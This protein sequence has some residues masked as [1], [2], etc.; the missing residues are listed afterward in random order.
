MIKI[1]GEYQGEL[2]CVARHENSGDTLN[3]DAPKDNQGRGAAFSPTDLVAT[4]LATCIATTMAIAVRKTPEVDLRGLKFEVTKEMSTY[5]P[6][7]IA[8]LTTHLWMP[9]RKTDAV[10][11]VL[12]HAAHNCPVHLSLDPSVEKVVI[13]HWPGEA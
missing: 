2:H 11:K 8:R 3:T 6:R 12:E 13:F 4:S 1:T 5:G 7:R 9:M 10:A